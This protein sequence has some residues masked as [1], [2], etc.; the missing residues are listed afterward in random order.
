MDRVVVQ[1]LAIALGIINTR[2]WTAASSVGTE[3]TRRARK[4][5]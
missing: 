4:A 2:S 3:A 5:A 1:A